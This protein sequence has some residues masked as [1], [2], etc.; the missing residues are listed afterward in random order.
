RALMQR[1][2][3]AIQALKP[4]FMMSPMSV[5][6][7]L[8]AGQFHFD[9]VIMDEASQIRPEDALG[10]IARGKSIV[11]VGDP[12]Q[13]PPTDFFKKATSEANDNEE[14]HS[15]LE[16]SKSILDSFM[17][18]FNTRCLSWHYRSQ[19]QS[20]ITF[21]NQ[22]FYD[23]N[24]IIFPSCIKSSSDLGV[25]RHYIKQAEFI[26]SINAKEA[27]VV[28]QYI[29]DTL[30]INPMA[31]I[32]VVA[33]NQ[34][35]S[36]EI[37]RYLEELLYQDKILQQ[38]YQANQQ[39][40]EPLFIKNLE[41][42]QGDER[43]TIII[44]MTYGC[45]PV[46]QKV[47][48]RFGPINY[49]DGW[50]RLNVLLTRAKRKM[51]IFTSMHSSDILCSESAV[52]RGKKALKAFLH[53][54]ESGHSHMPIK[55]GKSPQSDF[56]IAVIDMLQSHGY[57]CE[58]QLGVAGYYLDIAVIDPNNPGQYLLAIECDGASYHSAKSARDRDHL[59]QSILENL[60]WKIIRIWSSDWFKNPHAQIQPI[61]NALEKAS[62]REF[63]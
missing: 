13:L 61:L 30:A 28:A 2:G 22:E 10:A 34:A 47:A 53:F 27:Q 57:Q 35:Q 4:C 45:D 39:S 9:I 49:S 21:S 6:Q 12:K 58:A 7:Y 8:A 15:A 40:S 63:A 5:A 36:S 25:H 33:M 38:A 18:V 51:E 11:V 32:G 55:T 31:S 29:A 62:N 44:S 26:K 1:A 43:D 50:R 19:H 41:N 24:L 56:E 23:S 54:C 17:P 37:E 59:R 20:L 48:Q 52:Q 16:T 46:T 14:E 3:G 60:G 42:V